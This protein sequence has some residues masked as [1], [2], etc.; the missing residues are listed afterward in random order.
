M[1][2]YDEQLMSEYLRKHLNTHLELSNVGILFLSCVYE[3]NKEHK[4]S[5]Q[6]VNINRKLDLHKLF[7]LLSAIEKCTGMLL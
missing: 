4:T 1:F 6:T 5:T 7:S 3:G 2:C